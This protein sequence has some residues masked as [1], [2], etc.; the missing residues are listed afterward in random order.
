MRF[1]L[2]TKLLCNTPVIRNPINVTKQTLLACSSLTYSN[3]NRIWISQCFWVLFSRQVLKCSAETPPAFLC[4]CF[5]SFQIVHSVVQIKYTLLFWLHLSN[6]VLSAACI[7]TSSTSQLL[8]WMSMHNPSKNT[9]LENI[10]HRTIVV[11]VCN[12][13]RDTGYCP[14][15]S[16]RAACEL[17]LS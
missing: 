1:V 16:N 13:Y 4:C 8:W 11:G 12:G 14:Y 3:A 10:G 2:L 15:I 5:F 6:C 7:S 17:Q 9:S